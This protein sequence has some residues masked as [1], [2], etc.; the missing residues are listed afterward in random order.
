MHVRD[1]SM[2]GRYPF[3]RR[4]AAYLLAIA[5]VAIATVTT[6]MT[7]PIL[8]EV[9]P[10]FFVAV[11]LS[12]WYGGLGAGLVA[13]ALAGWASAYFF[14]D[15]P[16]G[17]GVFGWDDALRVGI[18][19][20]VALLISWLIHLRQ[21]AEDA[22]KRA[23][24][25]LEDRVRAR[26]R[27]L[28]L[29]IAELKRLEN[30]VL[31]ISEKE[32]RRIGHDLHD[33]LG[34]ELTGVAFLCENLGRRLNQYATSEAADVERISR[35]VEQAL[36]HTRELA[37]GL[38]PV[39]MGSDSLL[40]AL[41]RLV[42]QTQAMCR[43]PCELHLNDSVRVNDHS[44]AV[45]LY[46]I[47]QEALTNAVRHSG[48]SR[49]WVRLEQSIRDLVLT[50]EDNGIGMSTDGVNGKGMGIH[51]MQ[52]RARTIGAM[53]SIEHRSDGGT[54]IRCVYSGGSSTEDSGSGASL[55]HE[56]ERQSA[57]QQ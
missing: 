21:R 5:L 30:E 57:I 41:R 29:S 14:Y 36:E 44:A 32:Q 15:F 7:Q 26:T 20:L 1:A 34:Q 16:A 10:F 24:D 25:D 2:P 56:H 48:A 33:G 39:E 51:L 3:A 50:V 28:E 54:S 19:L 46:R 6:R 17:S 53:L 43:V 4:A 42:E 12:T 45:N 27:E 37:R 31:E 11:V 22:L 49:I 38:S 18:F 52:Y 47:A 35:L 55:S 13:T 40:A 9:S 8:G 23:N